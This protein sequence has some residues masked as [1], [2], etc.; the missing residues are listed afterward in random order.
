MLVKPRAISELYNPPGVPVYSLGVDAKR[1]EFSLEALAG[2]LRTGL[3]IRS[4]DELTLARAYTS[5]G[6]CRGDSESRQ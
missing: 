3:R 6:M 1:L 2:R 4:F 5:S